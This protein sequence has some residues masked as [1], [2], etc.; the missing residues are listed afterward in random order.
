MY[1][2]IH[3]DKTMDHEYLIRRAKE[4]SEKYQGDSIY[5]PRGD[6][7]GVIPHHELSMNCTPIEDILRELIKRPGW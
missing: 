4:I 6:S 7:S 3:G 1:L 2:K 5:M